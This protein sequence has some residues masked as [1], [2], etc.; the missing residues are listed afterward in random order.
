MTVAGEGPL[1]G[2]PS[3]DRISG[4]DR[5][6]RARAISHETAEQLFR[7]LR[8]TD[9]QTREPAVTYVIAASTMAMS[10][11]VVPPLTPTPAITWSS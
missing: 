2:Q 9:Q 4:R 11:S 6:G 7:V 8:Q 5:A 1:R 10:C 3:R